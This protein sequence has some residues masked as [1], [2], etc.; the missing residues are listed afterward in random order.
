MIKNVHNTVINLKT[1]KSNMKVDFEGCSII[2]I[3]DSK[4]LMQLRDNKKGIFYPNHWCIPGGK[5]EKDENSETAIVRELKEE[6]GYVLTKPFHFYTDTYKTNDDITIRR[7]IFIEIYDGKQHISS[8]EGQ[9]MEF[10]SVDEILKLKIFP[11]QKQVILKA[12]KIYQ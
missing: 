10:K 11:K 2:L 12:L 5:L 7:N 6:T 9:K 3:K 8:F 4:V 1:H